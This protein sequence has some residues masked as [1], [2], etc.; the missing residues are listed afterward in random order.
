MLLTQDLWPFPWLTMSAD[1]LGSVSGFVAIV[2]VFCVFLGKSPGIT[3]PESAGLSVQAHSPH[4]HS[5]E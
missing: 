4:L 2:S 3:E 5:K 1:V